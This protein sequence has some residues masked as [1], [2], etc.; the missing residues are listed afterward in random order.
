MSNVIDFLEMIGQ[1][2]RLRHASQDEM[3]LALANVQ[4]DSDL[5]AAILAKDQPQ[6]EAL[7]G[8][9]NT[10]CVVFPCIV[11][12]MQFVSMNDEDEIHRERRA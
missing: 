3:K 10:C 9:S 6:L 2:A 1:D 12:C 7:L 4:M 5:Q 8:A 11:S